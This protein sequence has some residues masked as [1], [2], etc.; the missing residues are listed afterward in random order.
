METPVFSGIYPD[1]PQVLVTSFKPCDDGDGWMV[2]LLNSSDSSVRTKLISNKN[3]I[4]Q[5]W[6]SNTGEEKLEE[7]PGNPE[8]PAWGVTIIRVK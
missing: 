4:Q 5:V 8:L 3:P 6:K 7:I 2:T 1:Q